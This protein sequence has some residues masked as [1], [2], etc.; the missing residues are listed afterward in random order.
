MIKARYTTDESLRNLLGT[1]E[2]ETLEFKR[3]V[4]STASPAHGD[5]REARRAITAAPGRRTWAPRMRP[6]R[7]PPA[8]APHRHGA[9]SLP[10]GAPA[11]GAAGGLFYYVPD[12]GD[13]PAGRTLPSLMLASASRQLQLSAP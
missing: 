6:A 8:G 2:S 4:W 13:L 11:G 9:R 12:P 5:P 10:G 1:E 7:P 3:E